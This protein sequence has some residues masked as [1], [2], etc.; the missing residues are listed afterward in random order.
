MVLSFNSLISIKNLG[1]KNSKILMELV[2]NVVLYDKSKSTP[3]YE[4]E[5]TKET[6]NIECVCLIN[7]YECMCV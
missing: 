7:S 1:V 3:P 6:H 4:V 2:L 5:T